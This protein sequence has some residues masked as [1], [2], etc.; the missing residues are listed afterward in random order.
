[1]VE[2]LR[3]IPVSS[4]ILDSVV[5]Q[6]RKDQA[7]Q[8]DIAEARKHI[9]ELQQLTADLITKHI[10]L[11]PSDDIVN[12]RSCF[13]EDFNKRP[14]RLLNYSV[15]LCCKVPVAGDKDVDVEVWANMYPV[16]V[17]KTEY[18][19]E[20]REANKYFVLTPALGSKIVVNGNLCEYSP[21]D[22]TCLVGQY[23]GKGEGME[24]KDVREYKELIARLMQDDVTVK[25]LLYGRDRYKCDLSV[26]KQLHKKEKT[27][28]ATAYSYSS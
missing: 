15:T 19:V 25:P 14:E 21:E 10:S 2:A 23:Q 6:R 24:P 5:G 7:R 12:T 17:D 22:A 26:Y 27:P 18:H 9:P 3:G 28:E 20:I 16:V 11:P 13:T 8:V 1:M 4:T